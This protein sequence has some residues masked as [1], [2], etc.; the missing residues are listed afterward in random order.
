[1]CYPA[2]THSLADRPTLGDVAMC[3]CGTI[4]LTVCGITIRLAPEAFGEML[5]MCQDAA[6]RLMLLAELTPGASRLAN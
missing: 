5:R 6:E 3:T 1:M 4:H 2:R